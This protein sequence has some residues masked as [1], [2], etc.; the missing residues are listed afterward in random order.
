MNS[1]MQIKLGETYA[2]HRGLTLLTVST[3]AAVD[4]KVLPKFKG[5]AGCTLRKAQNVLH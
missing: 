3:Y 2:A 5:R 4:G 1:G